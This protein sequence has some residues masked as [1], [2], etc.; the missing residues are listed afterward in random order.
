MS[1]KF[2]SESETKCPSIQSQ[3]PKIVFVLDP[4]TRNA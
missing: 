2:E 3:V 1:R 4:K